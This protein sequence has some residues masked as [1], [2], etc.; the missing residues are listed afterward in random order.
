MSNH[1]RKAINVLKKEGSIVILP[2]DK[3]KAT[4]VLDKQEYSEKAEILLSDKKTYEELPSDPTQKYKRKLVA[5][6]TRLT[7]EEKITKTKYKQLYP[8]AENVPRLYCTPQ[9]H[10]P[11]A[12]LRPIVDYTSTI[13]YETSRWLADIPA[14]MVG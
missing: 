2:A 6:L 9:I 10:K 14:P 8:T 1:E 5:I 7:N 3:G 13:G 12:P 11:N 4:V